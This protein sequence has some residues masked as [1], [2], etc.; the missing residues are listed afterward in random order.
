MDESKVDSDGHKIPEGHD[1]TEK[2]VAENA[3]VLQS[4]MRVKD[5]SIANRLPSPRKNEKPIIVKFVRRVSKTEM[6]KKKKA[7]NDN[8]QFCSVKI[9]EDITQPEL[10]LYKHMKIHKL[11]APG[12]KGS[13]FTYIGKADKKLY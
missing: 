13:Q 1:V 5:I 10:I 9:F 11:K 12:P 2:K 3:E 8:N 7:L 4:P 6:M